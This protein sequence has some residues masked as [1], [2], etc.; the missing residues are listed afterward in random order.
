MSLRE[1]H[2]RLAHP[3]EFLQRI[4]H[5]LLWHRIA[6]LISFI[7]S[8]L[9]S[10]FFFLHRGVLALAWPLIP[11]SPNPECGQPSAG[12]TSSLFFSDDNYQAAAVANSIVVDFL[13]HFKR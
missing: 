7:K 12:A 13:L 2:H 11:C 9:F 4:C 6:T 1:N 10:K 5:S 3:D 8:R